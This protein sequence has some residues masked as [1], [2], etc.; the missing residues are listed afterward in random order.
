MKKTFKLLTAA[1]FI[2]L[3]MCLCAVVLAGQVYDRATKTL[4]AGAGTWTNTVEYSALK[5]VRIWI[6]GSTVAANT[7]TVSRVTSDG[8]YTQTVG[9]V[10][11]TSGS[12]GNT[13]TF[14]AAYLKHGDKLT[15][16]SGT[17]SNSTAIIEYEVQQH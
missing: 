3:V 10:A 17:A 8:T 11:F 2:A 6:E 4:T 15:F 5:L 1:L 9:S 14:T 7:V 16:S 13:A 12:K